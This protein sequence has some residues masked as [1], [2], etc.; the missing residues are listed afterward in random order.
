M[1]KLQ[2]PKLY[3]QLTLSA[4]IIGMILTSNAFAHGRHSGGYAGNAS[5]RSSGHNGFG[6]HSFASADSRANAPGDNQSFAGTDQNQSVATASNPRKHERVPD[7]EELQ[8][9]ER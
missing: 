2:R 3:R 1:R 7:E 8:Q 5:N 4:A 6:R 9:P